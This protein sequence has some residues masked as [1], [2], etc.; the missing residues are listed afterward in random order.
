MGFNKKYL[1]NYDFLKSGTKRRSGRKISKLGFVVGHDTGNKNS[2]AKNNADYYSNTVND[3]SASA[4]TFIDDKEIREI[5]P[6]T[7]KSPEKAWHVIYNEPT[8]NLAYGDDANDIAAGVELCYGD[9]INSNEAYKRYVWYIA[10][11]IYLY[12]LNPYTDVTGH[13]I[14]DPQRRSDPVNALNRMGKT[15]TE[16]LLDVIKEYNECKNNEPDED[17]PDLPDQ[18]EP[19]RKVLRHKDKGIEVKQMEQ[20]LLSLGYFDDEQYLDNYFGTHT[21]EMVKKFQKE[22]GLSVDGVVGPN[23]WAE[24]NEELEKL[25]NKSSTVLLEEGMS[26]GEV[27][28]LEKKL[29]FL[30]YDIGKY[31][32][33]YFGTV[34]VDALKQFQKDSGLQVT[35]ELDKKTN[36]VLLKVYN[37]RKNKDLVEGYNIFRM[38]DSDIH[39]YLTN[40]EEKVTVEVGK[41]GVLEKL[42]DI[43]TTSKAKINGGFFDSK[44]KREHL[45][46]LIRDGLYYYPPSEQFIDFIYYKSG[47]TLITNL[48]GYNGA[49]LS[50][51]QEGT[52]W[53]IGTSWSL[54]QLGK[55]NLENAG[56]IAHSKWKNPRTFIGQRMDGNFVLC[57][58]DGRNS[59]S[60][61]VTATQEAEIAKFL[62]CYNAANLDGGGSSEMVVGDKTVNE[63]SDGQSRAIGSAIVVK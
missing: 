22:N 15:W 1:I 47:R 29:E 16:F 28:A 23:T 21:V 39:V 8:D 60:K 61:G 43:F 52:H 26:G 41:Y 31:L 6:I 44:G 30:G 38:F 19:S 9:N 45:G 11:I 34:T 27:L 12:D 50:Q 20:I 36:D 48:D 63:P 46:M 53:A 49:L 59:K 3:V 32:D 42:K 2:T 55:V 35:G 57:V 51:L 4:H 54:V 14:L 5:I 56:K 25:K 24:I 37:K 18:N 10:Y 17:K 40:D 58:V 13:F 33:T 62:E 7:T